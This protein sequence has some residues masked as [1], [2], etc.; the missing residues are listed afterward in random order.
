[1]FFYFFRLFLIERA[2]CVVKVESQRFS[3]YP[4]TV[5]SLPEAQIAFEGAKAWILQSTAS[6]LVFFQFEANTDLPPRSHNYVQWG[7][8][9]E[10]EMELTVGGKPRLCRKGDEYIV[11]AGESHSARFLRKTRVMDYFPERHRYTCKPK[12]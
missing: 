2:T 10:G 1:M 9:I 7:M 6:Q 12:K 4:E 5:T 3:G 8:V 11:P